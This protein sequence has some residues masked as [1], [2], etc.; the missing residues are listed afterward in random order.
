MKRRP[1]LGSLLAG[2]LLVTGLLAAPSSSEARAKS[3][4][5]ACVIGPGGEKV[6]ICMVLYIQ[7]C[8]YDTDCTC[9]E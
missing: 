1:L 2:A 9:S 3:Y 7:E 6:P 8:R 4:A 5:C